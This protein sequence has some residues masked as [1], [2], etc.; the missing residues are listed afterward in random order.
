MQ[1]LILH[2]AASAE[3]FTIAL[4][5]LEDIRLY[6]A[7][8]DFSVRSVYSPKDAPILEEPVQNLLAHQLEERRRTQYTVS[9]EPEV[10]RKKKPDI[11]LAHPSC[12]GPVTLEIKIAERWTVSE[13][14]AAIRDQLVGQYMRDNNSR[15]GVLLLCSSGPPKK[16]N[17][18]TSRQTLG[19]SELVE[20][21]CGFADALASSEGKVRG[22]RVVTIDF[23]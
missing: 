23:H 22:L 9:R 10:T 1:S 5:R 15:Y 18:A 17:D 13:L 7:D 21:L 14:E 16:W 4:N 19:F 11:R 2:P 12:G 20:H 8:G 3:L 6:L